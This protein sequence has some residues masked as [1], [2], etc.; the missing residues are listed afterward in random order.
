MWNLQK[1]AH[2]LPFIL[3]PRAARAFQKIKPRNLIAHF[4]RIQPTLSSW[5]QCARHTQ[6]EP[7]RATKH[8]LIIWRL[9]RRCTIIIFKDEEPLPVCCV[10]NVSPFTKWPLLGEDQCRR[11]GDSAPVRR[12]VHSKRSSRD[13]HERFSSTKN[14]IVFAGCR[15]MNLQWSDRKFWNSMQD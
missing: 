6:F 5:T 14:R 2:T 8:W 9:T 4:P 15:W 13:F 3:S 10:K 7:L 11:G 1:M 12:E